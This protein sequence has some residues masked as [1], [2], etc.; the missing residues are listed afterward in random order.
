MS[1]EPAPC[2]CKLDLA[3]LDEWENGGVG[4]ASSGRTGGWSRPVFSIVDL[5]QMHGPLSGLVHLP[6]AVYSSG[7]GPAEQ[8]DFADPD[9]RR[10][11]YQI[12]LTSG[13]ADDAARL[14]DAGELLRLWP[15]MWLPAH[16]RRAWEPHLAGRLPH[17]ANAG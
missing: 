1:K 3:Q 13:D 12:V 11:A 4:V 14:L 5:E 6:L 15:S 9:D 16:V 10:A 17:S 7:A 2:R 8:F